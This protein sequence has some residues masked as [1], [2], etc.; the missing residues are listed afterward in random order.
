MAKIAVYPG[1]FDPITKGHLDIIKRGS[2]LFDKLIVAV[3]NNS[4]KKCMFTFE[5]RV[6]MLREITAEMEN[7]EID[8]FSGLLIDYCK[9]KRVN[10][11]VRGLRAI[12]DFEYELQMAQMN[13]QLNSE[14]ETIFLTTSTKYSFLSSTL[15][16]EVAGLNGDISEFVP[17][18]V[19]REL[20]KKLKGDE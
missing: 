12:S 15:V 4:Q 6:E 5:E 9:K 13:R 17:S 14:T 8:A 18:I 1:S 3:L 19:L 20:N 11:I 10:A 2:K 16:K 7:V